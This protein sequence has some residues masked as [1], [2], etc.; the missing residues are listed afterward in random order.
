[1]C[2]VIIIS[3]NVNSY[4]RNYHFH[5]ITLVILTVSKP[6]VATLIMPNRNGKIR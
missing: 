4:N 5:V 2:D 6:G 3:F 1:M